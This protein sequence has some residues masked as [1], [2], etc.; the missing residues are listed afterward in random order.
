[1]QTLLNIFLLGVIIVFIAD[2][3]GAVDNLIKPLIKRILGIPSQKDIT[4]KPFDCSL[5][6][7]FW[8]GVIYILVTG[9]FTLLYLAYVCI[10]SFL[11]PVIKDILILVKDISHFVNDVIYKRLR[12]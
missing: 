2:L 1:M 10:I 4:I 12:I 9:R 8:S 3:S 6:L 7:T 11:T 5:C